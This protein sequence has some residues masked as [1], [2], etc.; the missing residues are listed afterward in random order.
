MTS[1][2]MGNESRRRYAAEQSREEPGNNELPRPGRAGELSDGRGG[3]NR[4]GAG[5]LPTIKRIL[6]SAL[7]R[8]QFLSDE[9]GSTN[10]SW[11]PFHSPATTWP[12]G[13]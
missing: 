11:E 6:A 2:N 12:A 9:R 5:D 10:C 4:T 13:H 3:G 8:G 7:S 1:I